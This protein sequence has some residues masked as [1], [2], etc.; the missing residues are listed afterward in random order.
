MTRFHLR[1][2]MILVAL[3]AVGLW[4]AITISRIWATVS[5]LRSESAAVRSPAYAILVLAVIAS[6]SL[7]VIGVIGLALRLWRLR[8]VLRSSPFGSSRTQ[9]DR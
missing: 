4:A 3:A 8:V 7:I 9:P 2:L 5:M 1:S 6:L